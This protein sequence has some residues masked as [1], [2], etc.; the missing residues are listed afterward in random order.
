MNEKFAL[1]VEGLRYGPGDR[2]LFDS[3]NLR[4]ES[5]RC[6][7]LTGEN[8]AG[9]TTLLRILAGLQKPREG[10]FRLEGGDFAA[11][12]KMRRILQKRVLYL[13]QQ[14]YMFDGTVEYNLRFALSRSTG[15]GAKEELVERALE[16]VGMSGFRR[17]YARSLSGGER[18]RV[19]LARAWLASPTV[20]LLDEPTANLDAES[21]ERTL[22][23]LRQLRLQGMTLVLASHDPHHFTDLPD[24]IL[25]LHQGRIFHAAPPPTQKEGS[26][27]VIPLR[28]ELA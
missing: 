27:A 26:A 4:L 10:R 18:Q 21:R 9:K 3:M 16:W 13:H 19:A 28:Q 14:P 5:G 23:L 25:R 2:N 6:V 17:K 24:R 22:R 7:L 11:W 8:G 20:M 15:R 12:K 1:E